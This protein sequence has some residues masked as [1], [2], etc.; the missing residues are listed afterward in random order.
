MQGGFA[1]IGL[2]TLGLDK[3]SKRR[4][5]R[6]APPQMA[7]TENS[8]ADLAAQRQMLGTAPTDEEEIQKKMTR[9]NG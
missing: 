2:Q 6:T 9:Q 1:S 3:K 7:M 5:P 8:L 4:A